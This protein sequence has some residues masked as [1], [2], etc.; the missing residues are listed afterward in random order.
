MANYYEEIREEGKA[1]TRLNEY[2]QREGFSKSLDLDPDRI[3]KVVF[4]GM[5]SSYFAAF[6]A[7][8]Y[9]NEHKIESYIIPANR[10]LYYYRNIVGENTLL[11]LVSQ[12]GESIEI[13][14]LLEVFSN[15]DLKIGVTNTEDSTLSKR[16]KRRVFL[17]AGKEEST[18]SKTYINTLAALLKIGEIL[19]KEDRF[20]FEAISKKVEGYIQDEVSMVK[21][22]NPYFL[23]TGHTLLLGRGPSLSTVFQ[24]A[25]ILKE[26]AHF[27]AEGFDS[28]DFRHGPLD[29][30]TEGF[31]VIMFSP[32]DREE[33]FKKD[34]A[35]A[36]KII[37]QGGTVLL[38]T[39]KEVQ[40]GIPTYIIKDEP[41]TL[42]F[43]EIIPL[44]FMSCHIGWAKG[45]EPGALYNIGK[46]VTK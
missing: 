9:L 30:V 26:A 7:V 5:G 3:D 12:S 42:P 33:A 17:K 4:T 24:G 22:F 21:V 44:Q 25:L 28:Y 23:G 19:T 31:R 29:I 27:H 14:E 11:I 16:V 45:M 39:N 1:L 43:Y 10:L 40:G 15:H 34:I 8:M 6:P 46:V 35:L 38:V 36:K 2:L 20:E 41:Y 37:S 32:Y 13:K 18:T